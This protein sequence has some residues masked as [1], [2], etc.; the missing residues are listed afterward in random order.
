MPRRD[1]FT[2]RKDP[3]PIVQE[4]GW[5]PGPVKTGSEILA[6]TGIRSPDRPASSE[7]P[8]RLSY[9]SSILLRLRMCE[10]YFHFF[11]YTVACKRTVL[12]LAISYK[13]GNFYL[14]YNFPSVLVMNYITNASKER[15]QMPCR[16]PY[17]F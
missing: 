5:A 9:P 17:V 10:L 8:Y 16:E 12:I 1:P 7:S 4:A 2:P 14:P 13:K 15:N 6:S 3:V 11:I